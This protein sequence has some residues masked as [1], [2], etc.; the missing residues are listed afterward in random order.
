MQEVEQRRSSCR[1][2]Q[3]EGIEDRVDIFASLSPAIPLG[4]EGV[5]GKPAACP[6]LLARIVADRFEFLLV[7]RNAG[8][9]QKV[10][11]QVQ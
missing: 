5:F 9:V 11:R 8:R 2:G 10:P 3:G 7:C 6:F 1:E 4:E